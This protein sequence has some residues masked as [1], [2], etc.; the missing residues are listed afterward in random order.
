MP[1]GAGVRSTGLS[2]RVLQAAPNNHFL[3]LKACVEGVRAE[4]YDRGVWA[5]G[6]DSPLH[7]VR[8][9]HRCGAASRILGLDG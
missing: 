7:R 2:A 6:V 9:V 5:A 1:V 8:T 4:W 3:P